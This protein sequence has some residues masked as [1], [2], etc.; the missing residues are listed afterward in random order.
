MTESECEALNDAL[1][2]LAARLPEQP[3]MRIT[4]FQPDAR[5]T[6]GV[7]RTVSVR[8]RRLDADAQILVL[9]DGTRIPFDALV[10]LD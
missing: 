8:V 9:T 10:R 5:K 3:E 6:G 2:R 7:Y 1:V 4:Y